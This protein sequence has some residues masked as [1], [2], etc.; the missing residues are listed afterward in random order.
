MH[1]KVLEKCILNWFNFLDNSQ[2]QTVYNERL[3]LFPVYRHTIYRMVH[4][5]LSV[6]PSYVHNSKIYFLVIAFV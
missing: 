5:K 4:A 2:T 3:H 6:I 1:N